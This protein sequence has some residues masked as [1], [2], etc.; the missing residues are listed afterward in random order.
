MFRVFYG[1]GNLRADPAPHHVPGSGSNGHGTHRQRGTV[2]GI[3]ARLSI[4]R[5]VHDSASRF[6]RPYGTRDK[7]ASA[8]LGVVQRFVADIGVPRA[9]RTN[10]G[11]EY[12]NSTFVE[13]CNSLRTRRALTAPY[14]Q[15]Q[16]G[17][18][19]SGLSRAS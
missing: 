19:K 5:H 3:T 12:T 17:P 6:Q 15:Q 9:F 7:S 4:C 1:E 11:A 13:Y 16:N 18:V 10:N 8:I 14:T 2:P